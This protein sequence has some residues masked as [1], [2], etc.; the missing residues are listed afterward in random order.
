MK[1]V[2]T[3][4]EHQ[5]VDFLQEAWTYHGMA[6]FFSARSPRLIIVHCLMRINA[7][8]LK[9]A[10]H[11]T[12]L[13]EMQSAVLGS[14]SMSFLRFSTGVWLAPFYLLGRKRTGPAIG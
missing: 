2:Q 12:P 10:W 1:L 7:N 13:S 5:M 11:K 9:T 14:F 6:I 4:P 8:R 3:F